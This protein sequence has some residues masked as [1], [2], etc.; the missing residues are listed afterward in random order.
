[1]GLGISYD[2]RDDVDFPRSGVYFSSFY[3]L[4][5][6]KIFGPEGLLTPE[7]RS[8]SGWNIAKHAIKQIHPPFFNLN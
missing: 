8:S 3:E 2:S 1:M 7:T 4:G 5:N 6:K